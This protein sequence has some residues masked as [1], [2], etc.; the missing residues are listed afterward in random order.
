MLRWWTFAGGVAC[1]ILVAFFAAQA[2]GIVWLEDP[3]VLMTLAKPLA[4]LAGVLLLTLDVF[5]P[6]PSI[7]VMVA[8]GSLFGTSLGAIL[9]L[10]GSVGAVLTGF[11]VGRA[12]NGMIQRLVTPRQHERAGALLKRWGVVAIAASR[13]IPVLAE[14]VAIL[15]GS[16]PLTWAQALWAGIA[17]SIVP[18]VVYAWAGESALGFGMQT[19]IFGGVLAGTALVFFLG[20]RWSSSQNEGSNVEERS[21]CRSSTPS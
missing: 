13:P 7:L 19:A 12:G 11:A 9:S 1:L 6:V 15:A 3:S 2:S 18:C 8:N 5:L 10:I 17:G 20:R 16:S 21:E 4:A 14:T